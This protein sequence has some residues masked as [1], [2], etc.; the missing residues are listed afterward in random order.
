MAITKLCVPSHGNENNNKSSKGT[1]TKSNMGKSSSPRSDKE[2]LKSMGEEA[3]HQS[4]CRIPNEEPVHKW[5]TDEVEAHHQQMKKYDKQLN[6]ANNEIARLKELLRQEDEK[7]EAQ[8]ERLSQREQDAL[9]EIGDLQEQGQLAEKK[10]VATSIELRKLTARFETNTL[11]IKELHNESK[12]LNKDLRR[13]EK[14]L[15]KLNGNITK[16]EDSSNSLLASYSDLCNSSTKVFDGS[17]LLHD[18]L[19]IEK[20]MFHGLK[21]AVKAMQDR[22]M[23]EAEQRLEMQKSMAEMLYM[24]QSDCK[25]AK[26]ANACTREGLDCEARANLIMAELEAAEAAKE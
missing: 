9:K 26:L 6:K 25:N 4:F 21:E 22:Y 18:S 19:D 16:M 15:D 17:N 7:C 24:I 8:L 2:L 14:Q 12:L 13:Q 11:K 23:N 10:V 5:N 3:F 20:E 1:S